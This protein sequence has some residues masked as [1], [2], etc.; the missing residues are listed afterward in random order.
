[1]EIIDQEEV[2]L[3]FIPISHLKRQLSYLTSRDSIEYIPHILNHSDS[4]RQTQFPSNISDSGS[5]SEDDYEN[6]G[7]EVQNLLK[8]GGF[9]KSTLGVTSSFET[10]VSNTLGKKK[11]PFVL[12]LGYFDDTCEFLI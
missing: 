12:A 8:S 1:M 4:H 10:G 11:S 9:F 2:S 7:T 5:E 3:S 6:T